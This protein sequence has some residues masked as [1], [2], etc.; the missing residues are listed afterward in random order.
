[1]NVSKKGQWCGLF[2]VDMAGFNKPGR[3]HEIQ[4]YLRRSLYEILETAFDKSAVKW[5]E[6]MHEDRGDG[7]LVIV[8]PTVPATVLAGT[9][10]HL[11]R[12]LI[13]LHN[14]VSAENAQIRLRAAAH[15]GPVYSDE[16]G[17]VG[18]DVNFLYRMLDAQPLRRMLL[19]SDTDIA[20][21]MSEYFYD[22][23]VQSHPSL[24]SP[25]SFHAISIRVK[26]TRKRAWASALIS[27]QGG[28]STPRSL[29]VGGPLRDTAKS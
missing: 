4:I 16:H 13:R 23:I 25:D 17:F 22:N 3:D 15:V 10:P 19:E 28:H 12:D 2:A 14:H 26:E 24:I 8:P 6:C 11:L 5:S 27:T 9:V 20:F 29:G 7:V 18:H 1:V 21:V